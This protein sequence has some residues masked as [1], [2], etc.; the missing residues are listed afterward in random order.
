MVQRLCGTGPEL[1]PDRGQ[2]VL[3]RREHMCGAVLGIS[4]V[5]ADHSVEVG[6][7]EDQLVWC[8]PT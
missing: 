7:A 8:C 5:V 4:Q 6:E 1:D 2:Q 3:D